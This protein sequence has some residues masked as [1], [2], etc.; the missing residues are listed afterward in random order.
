[1][2]AETCK[3]LALEAGFTHAAVPGAPILKPLP[4][5]REMCAAN[6]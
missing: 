3:A 5:V 6:T 4:Q 2:E 1:M